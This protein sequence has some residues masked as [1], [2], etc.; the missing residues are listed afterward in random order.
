MAMAVERTILLPLFEGSRTPEE[1]RAAV[2]A[3]TAR[4]KVAHKTAGKKTRAKKA[5]AKKRPVKK[6]ATK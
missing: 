4:E 5:A 6:A 3:V 1:F 2:R